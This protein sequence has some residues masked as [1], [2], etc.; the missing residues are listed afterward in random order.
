MFS[1]TTMGVFAILAMISMAVLACGPTP[2]PTPQ[3][4][5]AQIE[6][7][8]TQ[9]PDEE[10]Q[11]EAP[12]EDAVRPVLQYAS[13]ADVDHLDPQNAQANPSEAVNHMIY[14]GVVEFDRELGL[15]PA[16]AEEMPTVSEDG[17]VWTIKCRKGIK[18]H[19]GTDF[20]CSSVKYMFDRVL[21]LIEADEHKPFKANLWD[22]M[23]KEARLLDDYTLE[24]EL[25]APFAF[26]YNNL[27][28]SASWIV[29]PAAHEKMKGAY[30]TPCAATDPDCASYAVGTGPF[31][32]M[33]WVENDH[34]TLV[35]NDDYWKGAPRLGGVNIAVV[36]EASAR[37]LG[38]EG[39][40]YQLAVRIPP[41]EVE[42]LQGVE[43]ITVD[44]G[45]TNRTLMAALQ[46]QI[47]PFSDVKVR[48]ALNYAVDKHR[49]V[50]EI[51]SGG[52]IQISTFVGP[53]GTGNANLDPIPYDPE[54]A[55][56]LLAEAGYP[57]GFETKMQIVQGRYLKDFEM[58]Q[59]IAKQ[60]GEVG[61]K[62]QLEQY[63]S[64]ALRDASA[65][66][67]V[68]IYISGWSPSTGEARWALYPVLHTGGDKVQN[69]KADGS[70]DCVTPGS[71]G[72]P[73]FWG[74]CG[75]NR[76]FYNNPTF[77]DALDKATSATTM[78]ERDEWLRK[79]Q[80]ELL[81]NPAAIWLV[82]PGQFT[83]MSDKLENPHISPLELVYVDETTSLEP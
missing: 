1:K 48:L 54:K 79:A 77:D 41:E 61:V 67:D 38:L 25:S 65:R 14:N 29:S 8:P 30:G 69:W 34:V 60:L 22:T 5:E 28:H 24:V 72:I 18:F 42:R 76:T 78:E 58:M 23:V 45:Q 52:A 19:D 9:P 32:F 31:K 4:T 56:E 16:L 49:I 40:T 74:L 7:A 6:L 70:K 36:P 46:N 20:D 82:S 62:V 75:S 50:D 21:G 47:E 12:P 71:D 37:M 64:N 63:D 81:V 57:N 11:A 59:E 55:K 2:A 13:G 39:G 27:A 33:E 17:L 26:F 15:H 51:Y 83:G 80:E 10:E 73:D 3:P 53:L 35:A 44:I 66:G 68:T 43:G